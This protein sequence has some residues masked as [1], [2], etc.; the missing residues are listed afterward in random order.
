MN[1]TR[2]RTRQSS[3][4]MSTTS[5]QKPYTQRRLKTKP[6]LILIAI[7]LAGN[8]LGF[9]AWL[10]PSSASEGGNEQV[11]S[12]AGEP[13]TRQQWM[14]AMEELY[15]KETLQNLVNVAVVEKAASKYD[16]DVS[17]EEIDMELALISSAQDQYDTS[18]QKLTTEQLRQ[19][20]RSQLILEKVLTKDVVIAEE[21]TKAYYDDNASLFNIPTTYRT[22][23]IVVA[24]REEADSVAK[25][26]KNGSTF[27]TLAR[28][29]S[30]EAASAS[31]GG[32]IG[33]VSEQDANVDEAIP[34]V[35]KGLKK[36][37][38]SEPFALSDGRYGV[39]YVSDMLK[40]QSFAYEDVKDHIQRELALEQ[41]PKT[42][43]AEALWSEFDASWFYGE[44]K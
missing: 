9:I 3:P 5:N 21:K 25:E 35:L 18:L 40:G 16:I 31:L 10:I 7:L 2:N 29:R 33:F 43:T 27:S 34:V 12:V 44:A 41:L 14:A 13:I 20:I 11:A 39:V 42:V 8:V 4:A 26:L 15:G 32:D 38:T 6:V 37:E 36:G 28:E 1:S 23:V 19:K 17:D 30:L 22:S 24:T